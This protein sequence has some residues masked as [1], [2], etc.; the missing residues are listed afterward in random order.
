MSKACKLDGKV[1]SKKLQELTKDA[2][3]NRLINSFSNKSGVSIGVLSRLLN[4]KQ[5]RITHPLTL[6][7]IA[8]ASEG[9]VSPESILIAGGYDPIKY[10]SK[11]ELEMNRDNTVY[12]FAR[13]C[14]SDK[15]WNMGGIPTK[16]NYYLKKL[17]W[18]IDSDELEE[19]YNA[20]RIIWKLDNKYNKGK[21][22]KF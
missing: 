12:N 22:N 2:L 21:K 3:G 10:I 5:Q 14:L 16:E 15:E 18:N 8:K 20:L 9:R 1:D 19:F 11:Y 6:K 17:E 7:K 13:H 4:N